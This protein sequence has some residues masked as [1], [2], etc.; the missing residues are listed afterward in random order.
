RLSARYC[1]W[2]P[3][4]GKLSLESVAHDQ[5]PSCMSLLNVTVIS[6]SCG[7]T[8]PAP[9]SGTV[10]T[11][12]GGTDSRVTSSARTAVPAR[13]LTRATRITSTRFIAL[14]LDCTS[15]G[16]DAGDP[17]PPA[18]PSPYCPTP[19]ALDRLP[20]PARRHGAKLE[21]TCTPQCP[22][23]HVTTQSAW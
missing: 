18:Q 3:S 4:F 14:L 15:R 5:L 8:A 19:T 20:L 11:T 2:P 9:A 23:T 10:F 22:W 17:A 21:R 13:P 7:S 1:G 16:R 12:T 6:V